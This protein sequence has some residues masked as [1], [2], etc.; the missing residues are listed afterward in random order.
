MLIV[1][2]I[3]VGKLNPCIDMVTKSCP[4]DET[5]GQYRIN[6]FRLLPGLL[7]LQ[8]MSLHNKG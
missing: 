4:K 1:Q 7:F 2:R 8:E 3:L 6:L 5:L